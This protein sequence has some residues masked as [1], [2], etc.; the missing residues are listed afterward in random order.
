MQKVRSNFI[1]NFYYNLSLK[2]T[3]LVYQC[4]MILMV[5]KQAKQLLSDK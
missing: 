5:A 2:N 1:F 4:S 3:G